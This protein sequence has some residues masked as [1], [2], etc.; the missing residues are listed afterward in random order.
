[1]QE[2]PFEEQGQSYAAAITCCTCYFPSFVIVRIKKKVTIFIASIVVA[3][4]F[5]SSESTGHWN[6]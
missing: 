2:E 1:L 3:G 4:R 5:P 6:C